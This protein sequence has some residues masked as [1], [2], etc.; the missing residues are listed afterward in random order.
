MLALGGI[1]AHLGHRLVA[2]IQPFAGHQFSLVASGLRIEIC[3]EI[4]ICL[5]TFS[6]S[7]CL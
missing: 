3:V 7:I 2:A 6:I 5:G 4:A 1:Q